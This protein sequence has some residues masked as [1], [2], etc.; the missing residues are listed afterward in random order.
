MKSGQELTKTFKLFIDEHKIVNLIFL[1]EQR[2]PE[3]S[4]R[5]AELIL[6]S[7]AKILKESPEEKFKLL[8]DLSP[9]DGASY[10]S[11]SARKLYSESRLY[12]QFIKVG[13]VTSSILAKLLVYFITKATKRSEFVR[14]FE[15]KEEA[16]EWLQK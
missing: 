2:D 10:L 9:S 12:E 13:V 4:T 14:L 16:L 3:D 6:K 7:F 5:Q 8:V 1:E 11:D 15:E